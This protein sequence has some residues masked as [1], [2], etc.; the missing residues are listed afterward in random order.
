MPAEAPGTG[1]ESPVLRL[2]DGFLARL[3][4]LHAFG[5]TL[6]LSVMFVL[7]ATNVLLRYLFASGIAWAYEIHA[8]LLPWVV[9]CGMVLAACE[10]RHVAIRLLLDRLAPAAAR[11]L[12]ML[13]QALVLAASLPVLWASPPVLR[14]ASFQSLSTL[15]ITQV[16]GYAALVWAFAALALVALVEMLRLAL[17]AT[18]TGGRESPS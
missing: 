6:C 11:R 14:A 5:A 1:A 7:L 17:G 13:V 3:A 2:A 10:G 12:A 18:V 16:W 9:A 8:L 4:Q 15:G